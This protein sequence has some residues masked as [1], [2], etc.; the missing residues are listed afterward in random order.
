MQK[1]G[2]LANMVKEGGE[3]ICLVCE[4]SPVSWT[5][6]DV[7]G[8][9]MCVTCGTPYQLLQYDENKRRVEG[10]PPRL[11]IKENW[12]PILKR[13][14]EETRAFT[15]LATI[16]IWRDYPECEEGQSNFYAWLDEHSE[17]IPEESD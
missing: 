11:N 13:Y 5:W 8:E 3:F 4:A 7:H 1:H 6:G 2:H 14:W 17:L 16:M 15:G 10:V 12:L 9:A